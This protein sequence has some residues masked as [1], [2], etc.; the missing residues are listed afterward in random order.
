MNMFAKGKHRCRFVF[1]N[2]ERCKRNAIRGWTMCARHHSAGDSVKNDRRKRKQVAA[3]N[4]EMFDEFAC[5]VIK[6]LEKS[7]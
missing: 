1:G 6:E 7:K 4:K 3:S 2:G 5:N